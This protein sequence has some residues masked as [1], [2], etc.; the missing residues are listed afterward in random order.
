MR[1]K[2]SKLIL[3]FLLVGTGLSTQRAIAQEESLPDTVAKLLALVEELQTKIDE[4]EAKIQTLEGQPSAE[5]ETD[6]ASNSEA[7]APDNL[8]IECDAPLS[9][10]IGTGGMTAT[11]S[12]LEV[13]PEKLRIWYT[14]KNNVSHATRDWIFEQ[15]TRQ[16]ETYLIDGEN[17]RYAYLDTS[18]P[19]DIITVAPDDIYKFWVDYERPDLSNRLLTLL[20]YGAQRQL[21]PTNWSDIQQVEEN[22][23]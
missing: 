5:S 15:Q 10:P 1:K 14:A 8:T 2:I 18:F 6:E 12:E 11:I 3:C 17:I 4:L 21:N 7:P 22:G 19:L 16:D 13:F 20:Y 23:C 9:K